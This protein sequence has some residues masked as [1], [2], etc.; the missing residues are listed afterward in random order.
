MV[1]EAE[2]R[3]SRILTMIRHCILQVLR[4]AVCRPSLTLAA[5]T[6]H[7]RHYNVDRILHKVDDC[8]FRAPV[9]GEGAVES[10]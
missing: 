7:S 4:H 2:A 1:R 10:R 5:C 9:R 3:V 8:Y 6:S